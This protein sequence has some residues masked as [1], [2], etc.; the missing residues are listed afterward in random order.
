MPT[1]KT[2]DR[3]PA[4]TSRR[5]FFKMLAASPLLG[6]V[7]PG[8]PALWQ[9]GVEREWRAA[10]GQAQGNLNVYLERQLEGQLIESV[11]EAV[12]VW[13]FEQVAHANNL[14][15]HW[16]Y[17]HMGV[18]D[19]ETRR[20]NREGFLRLQ[21]RPRRMGPDAA[22]LDTA[23]SF[24]GHR[25]NT[26][27]FLCPVAALEAYHTEGE[28]GAARAAKARGVLQIQSNQSSQSYEQI[29]EARGEPH[30]FQNYASPDW[31]RNKK[32]LDRVA[33]A[34]CPVLVWTVDLLGGSNRELSRRTLGRQEYDRPLCQNAHNHKAGYQRPMRRG[35]EGPAGPR[36]PYD[37][38]YIKRL[39]DVAPWKVV[40]KGIVT[41]EEAAEAVEAG[42]DGIFVS[43]HGG[44]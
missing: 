35:M 28:S 9:K 11:E 34:G 30:W 39:K 4:L 6:A 18:D 41:R 42:A 22:K 31:T 38:A 5:H 17:L 25:W 8:L 40:V 16:A 14:P 44:R 36:Y 10:A 24:F 19:F 2:D 33:K 7:Y 15:Q 1:H 21:L 13:D 29:M 27:L 32:L 3:V 20:A 26:P 43:N 37:L 12:N 23:V